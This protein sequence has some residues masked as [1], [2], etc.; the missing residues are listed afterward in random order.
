M[1]ILQNIYKSITLFDLFNPVKKKKT[2]YLHST[3]T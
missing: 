3:E 2:P 1:S